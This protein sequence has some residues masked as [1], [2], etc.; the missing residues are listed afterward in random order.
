MALEMLGTFL[1]RN[2]VQNYVPTHRSSNE[3]I[4][5]DWLVFKAQ[6]S[7]NKRRPSIV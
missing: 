6:R 1:W 7:L 2:L 4:I 5:P 3:K